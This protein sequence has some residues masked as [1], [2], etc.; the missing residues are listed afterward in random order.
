M[1][2]WSRAGVVMLI[3]LASAPAFA[4]APAPPRPTGPIRLL[5]AS[6]KLPSVVDTPLHFKLLRVTVPAGQSSAYSGPPG[7]LLPLTGTV[8]VNVGGEQ[9]TLQEGEGIFVPGGQR[10]ALAAGRS[11]SATLLHYLL[12]ATADL[13]VDFY[14][15]P[16][17]VVELHRTPPIPNLSAGPYELSM[18]RVTVNPKLPAPPMHHRSGAALYYVMAGTWTLHMEGRDEPRERAHVQFEPNGFVH[19][20]ENVGSSTG[21]ILQANISP[22]GAP[23]IIFLPRPTR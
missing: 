18:T 19:T 8:T 6:G 15:K 14:E 22:E 7:V 21:V 3:L 4:Q 16:A 23:E 1:S 13:G 5:L 12:V 2:I 20:W 10:A 9:R 11:G 17:T